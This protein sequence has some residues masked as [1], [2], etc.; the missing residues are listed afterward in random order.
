MI[1]KKYVKSR[2]V[3]KA[4][5]EFAKTQLPEGAKA[6]SVQVVGDFNNWDPAAAPMRYSKKKKAFW[7]AVDL[8]PGHSYQFRYLVDG[9]EGMIRTFIVVAPLIVGVSTLAA[10]VMNA[11][12][13]FSWRGVGVFAAFVLC[14]AAA[15]AAVARWW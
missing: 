11:P 4:T 15:T 6:E 7:A 5:F 12:H 9:D 14:A 8:E 13:P 3:F 2:Q 1:K 10:Q